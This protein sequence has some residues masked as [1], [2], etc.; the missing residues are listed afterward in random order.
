[1]IQ[2]L[3]GPEPVPGESL[4]LFKGNIDQT[5]GTDW[6]DYTDT[7]VVVRLMEG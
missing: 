5:A 6:R 4:G 3:I 7:V 2:A 1:M